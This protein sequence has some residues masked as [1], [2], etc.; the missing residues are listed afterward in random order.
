MLRG[1]K[2][3]DSIGLPL[4]FGLLCFSTFLLMRRAGVLLSDDFFI[5]LRIA[6]HWLSTGQP[7]FNVDERVLGT[8]SP[9]YVGLLVVI[10]A[11]CGKSWFMGLL[12]LQSIVVA[13]LSLLV[14]S[15]VKNLS[16]TNLFA[17]LAA[18]SAMLLSIESALLGMET[19]LAL[20][21]M[22][23]SL[24]ILKQHPLAALAC[25]AVCVS[26]RLECLIFH[27]LVTGYL[28]LTS[29]RKV[30]CLL[31]SILYVV[32]VIGGVWIVFG[33]VI[34]QPAIAK[35]VVYQLS[36]SDSLSTWRS[37]FEVFFDPP[38]EMPNSQFQRATW[39]SF[40]LCLCAFVINRRYLSREIVGV[41]VMLWSF[42][43]LVI[44]GYITKGVLVFPWYVPLVLFPLGTAASI[45]G[46]AVPLAKN[47]LLAACLV[48]LTAYYPTWSLWGFYREE[49]ISNRELEAGRASRLLE[50]G[51]RINR[52]GTSYAVLASEIGAVGVGYTGI[53]RDGVGLVSPEALRYHPLRVGIERSAINEGVI[54]LKFVRAISPDVIVSLPGL[55]Q[56]GAVDALREDYALIREPVFL[57]DDAR[58]GSYRSIWGAEE[59]LILVRDKDLLTCFESNSSVYSDP[60]QLLREV[61]VGVGRAGGLSASPSFRETAIRPSQSP[62]E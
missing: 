34:P 55:I 21:L 25:S 54:P 36:W 57:G 22:T 49:L 59:V 62:I 24:L 19:P 29:H 31:V 20:A 14:F 2:Y 26:V 50:I 7:F 45:V 6:T 3:L 28:F 16:G 51:L 1:N 35:G 13:T 30:K 38:R 42:S 15:L 39:L 9:L 46:A 17:A 33:T 5:H 18:T 53:V 11:L 58:V 61:A 37:V 43:A 32:L 48:G 60:A 41:S 47:R 23:F 8:S 12:I 4:L 10:L 56:V 27:G 44:A 52:C 40:F